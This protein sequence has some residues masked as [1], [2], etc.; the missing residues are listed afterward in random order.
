MRRSRRCR[1]YTIALRDVWREVLACSLMCGI[2]LR[3][4]MAAPVNRL[5]EARHAD[6]AQDQQLWQNLHGIY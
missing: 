1:P 4:R 6:Y 5:Y 2:R 3:M